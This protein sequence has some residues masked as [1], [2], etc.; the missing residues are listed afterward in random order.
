MTRARGRA[1]SAS[2]TTTG[3]P[4]STYAARLNGGAEVDADDS[5]GTLGGVER[6]RA[7]ERPGSRRRAD[8]QQPSVLDPSRQRALRSRRTRSGRAGGEESRIRPSSPT[9]RRGGARIPFGE[10]RGQLRLR[11]G[12]RGPRAPF[13]PVRGGRG[14]PA[15]RRRRPC[16]APCAPRSSSRIS[17]KQAARRLR[18]A[19]RAE[20][21]ALLHQRGLHPAHRIAEGAIGRVHGGRGV[22]ATPAPRRTGVGS[23]PDEA[24]R[25]PEEAPL[26][27]G[28]VDARAGSRPS[29]AQWA[30]RR[31]RAGA[32]RTRGRRPAGAAR[33]SPSTSVRPARP[34]STANRTRSK[35]NR[36]SSEARSKCSV[37]STSTQ[38]G[39][40]LAPPV[41][42]SDRERLAAAAGLDFAFGLPNVKPPHQ[43]L[44]RSPASSRSGTG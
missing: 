31:G 14:A 32:A 40:P 2:R 13:A 15:P 11:A 29:T 3:R 7:A 34:S 41:T 12:A 21:H 17:S 42:G 26:Q 44:V 23:S 24:A 36:A 18:L 19:R 1:A 9:A 43:A 35:A 33:R 28:P 38:V 37:C 8:R 22:E 10:A 20:R 5:R 25:E 16:G 6:R 27:V 4:S 30:L 39:I